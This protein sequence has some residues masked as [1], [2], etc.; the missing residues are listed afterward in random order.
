MKVE[1][2]IFSGRPNPSWELTAAE[3]EEFRRWIRGL[4]R[5]QSGRSAPAKDKLGYRGLIVTSAGGDIESFEQVVVSAGSAQ[6]RSP[7][8][9]Q[10]FP[11]QDRALEQWLLAT[12]KN[13]LEADLYDEAFNELRPQKQSSQ[14]KPEVSQ[15]KIED[16]QQRHEQRLM[17]IPGVTGVGISELNGRP[18][19][20]IMVKQLTPELKKKLPNQL[21]GFAVKVE[22]SGEIRAQ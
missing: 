8:G 1:L 7:R 22:V 5:D 18:A 14:D 21:E 6:G 2:D 3:S 9:V 19:I 11:D 20:L 16:V 15:V 4:P 10:T 12:G 17:S 13:R